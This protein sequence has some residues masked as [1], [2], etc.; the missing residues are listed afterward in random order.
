[1]KVAALVAVRCHSYQKLGKG[2]TGMIAGA[3]RS[4]T[5]TR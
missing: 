2:V 5:H 1:V 3:G 4:S